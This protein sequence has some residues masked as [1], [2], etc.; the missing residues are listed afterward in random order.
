MSLHSSKKFKQVKKLRRIMLF[1]CQYPTQI[2]AKL[3]FNTLAMIGLFALMVCLENAQR[4][5]VGLN[6]IQILT[7]QYLI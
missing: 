1:L 5:G 3:T 7:Q 2:F 6:T 4:L